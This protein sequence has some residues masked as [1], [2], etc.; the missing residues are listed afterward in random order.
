LNDRHSPEPIHL[1]ELS[2]DV[3]GPVEQATALDRLSIETGPERVGEGEVY[4]LLEDSGGVQQDLCLFLGQSLFVGLLVEEVDG[5]DDLEYLP[6]PDAADDAD[7][8]R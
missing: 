1:L 4:A 5:L 8:L 3:P 6:L 2:L 7:L